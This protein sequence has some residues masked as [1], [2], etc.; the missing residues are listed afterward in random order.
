MSGEDYR[1]YNKEMEHLGLQVAVERKTCA[2]DFEGPQGRLI[3]HMRGEVVQIATGDPM[4]YGCVKIRFSDAARVKLLGWE[5]SEQWFLT[6]AL[7]RVTA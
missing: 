7:S 2:T 5:S 4:Y 3:R 1:L 6:G